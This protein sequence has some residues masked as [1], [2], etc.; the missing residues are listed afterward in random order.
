MLKKKLK[1]IKDFKSKFTNLKN[2]KIKKLRFHPKGILRKMQYLG[3]LK[4]KEN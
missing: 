3:E 1:K 4:Y 2:K